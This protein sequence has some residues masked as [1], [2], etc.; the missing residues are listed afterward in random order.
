M[1]NKTDPATI[2]ATRQFSWNAFGVR[3][4][5]VFVLPAG[6]KN[7]RAMIEQAADALSRKECQQLHISPKDNPVTKRDRSLV[8]AVLSSLGIKA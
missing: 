6:N 1:K 3:Q 2:K 7:V 8:I 4:R 5:R